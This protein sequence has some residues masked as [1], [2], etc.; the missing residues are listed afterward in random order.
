M[1]ESLNEMAMKW[2]YEGMNKWM[3]RWMDEWM[4]WIGETN[5]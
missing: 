3:D 2:P 5:E 4:N 1:D